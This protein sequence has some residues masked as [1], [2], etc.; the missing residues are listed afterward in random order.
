MLRRA[1]DA[2]LE[3]RQFDLPD[4]DPVFALVERN[5]AYLR[6]W[7]PWVDQ[8][9]TAGDVGEFIRGSMAQ[10]EAGLGPNCGIWLEGEL[11][12]S[13][14]C[15]TIDWANRKVSLGY[16][17]DAARQGSGIV[18]RC[19]ASMLDYLF[20]ELELHRVVIQC[21]T[22]NTRSCAIPRRLGFT[23]EGV[24]REAEW[25]AGRWVDLV[26][27][28]MLRQE[29]GRRFRVCPKGADYQWGKDPLE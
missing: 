2:G 17:V 6:E 20:E 23:R 7:L 14:G 15:H 3:M 1:V 5:R 18:T 9:H 11:A 10:H 13:I 21:G 12:G 28:S 19:C 26:V 16:W 4:A 27:W 25:T 24:E 29:W 8:T 22:G